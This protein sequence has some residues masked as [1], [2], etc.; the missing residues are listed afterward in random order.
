MNRT[1]L[2]LKKH[3]STILTMVGA[4]GVVGTAV[5][6]V[7]ATPKALQLIEEAKKEKGDELTPVETIKVAW[8]PYV[9]AAAIGL[10]TI[11]CIF[12]ANYLSV[13]SQASLMSA[14]AFL[15]NSYKE[16]RKKVGD[17]YG[18]DADLKVRGEV[19]NS[20]FNEDD[21]TDK[22]KLLFFDFQSMQF[23]ESTMEHV[24]E[25]ECAFKELITSQG[26]ACLN[27]YYDLLGIDHVKHGNQ[28][29][30]FDMENIDPYGSEELDFI[31]EKAV[32]RDGTEYW[33]IDTNT[34][35][36]TDYIL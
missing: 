32:T 30:W 19:A 33:I 34:S 21:I 13:K 5:L 22:N 14:Y 27:D 23:F 20:R 17:V 11:A 15:D 28:L 36:N 1:E 12:G 24:M 8:K 26:F 4:T 25:A 10:S 9:P 16:Y 35:P 3:S 7:K 31:Y 18:E 29:G 2:F 6:S